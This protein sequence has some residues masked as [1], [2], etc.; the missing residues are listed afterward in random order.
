MAKGD[1]ETALPNEGTCE[2][3]GSHAGEISF[4]GHLALLLFVFLPVICARLAIARS[5]A[6]S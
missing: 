3:F 4:A 2:P 5:Y 6:A 1:T